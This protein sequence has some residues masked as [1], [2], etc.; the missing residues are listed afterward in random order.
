MVKR[1]VN[2]GDWD[3]PKCGFLV[4]GTREECPKCGV[5]WNDERLEKKK[6]KRLRKQMALDPWQEAPVSEAEAGTWQQ[7]VDEPVTWL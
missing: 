2:Q 4:W 7:E 1:K 5:S 6:R 3:C